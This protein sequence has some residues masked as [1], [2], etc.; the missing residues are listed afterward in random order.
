VSEYTDALP[1]EELAEEIEELIGQWTLDRR[2]VLEPTWEEVVL[3]FRRKDGTKVW[4]HKEA[5]GWRSDTYV[6]VLKQKVLSAKALISDQVLQGGKLPVGLLPDKGTEE[7]LADQEEEV[8]GQADE[9]R[10]TEEA[11]LRSQLERTGSDAKY[12][13][14]LL[15]GALYGQAYARLRL[16]EREERMRVPV[17]E[18]V[19]MGDMGL[20]R[21]EEE[22]KV[23]EEL[24]W[25]VVSVWDV[26]RDYSAQDCQS[27]Q[28]VALR[29]RLSAAELRSISGDGQGW[30]GKNVEDVIAEAYE[31]EDDDGTGRGGAETTSGQPGLRDLKY[32]SAPLE[33]WEFWGRVP[34]AK[35]TQEDAGRKKGKP[36]DEAEVIAV[37][38]EGRLLRVMETEAARPV[39]VVSWWD[40]VDHLPASG[41]A[42]NLLDVQRMMNGAVRA[43]EDNKKL[44]AN[45]MP[46]VKDEMLAVPMKNWAPGETVR[47]VDEVEDVTKAVTILMFPDV[48]Q[49]L[50]EVIQ[51]AGSLADD[52][53]GVPRVQ[54]GQSA[55]GKETAYELSQ[56]LEKSGKLL[57]EVI[58]HYDELIEWLA[59]EFHAD[60]V[61]N[62]ELPDGQLGFRVQA[63][64]FTSF[65]ARLELIQSITQLL[66]VVG[67]NERLMGEVNWREVLEAMAKALDM[68]P[69]RFLNA[70]ENREEMEGA[71][72]EQQAAAMA[73]EQEMAAAALQVQQAKAMKDEAG[74]EKTAVDAK[75]AAE[76]LKL[77]QL[78][79]AKEAIAAAREGL[80]TGPETT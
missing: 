38:C 80:D 60:N 24:D 69:D 44:T 26:V 7:W 39:K 15:Q 32:H 37:V 42:E 11:R 67:Q 77:R 50:A 76:D 48:A 3:A 23:V 13:E 55:P 2:T 21:S 1:G 22:V 49:Q 53:S 57:G 78:R 5:Q 8:Q 12:G 59:G 47:V 64:G 31:D 71:M 56:R 9:W 29:S 41:I 4:K 33:V 25:A 6:A 10:E 30:L 54:Q 63:L 74:A 16:V 43:F 73:L 17:E 18:T 46:V 61:A 20:L 51:F 45:A 70:V 58:R 66:T 62:E 36:G 34:V 68:D 52:E 79:E 35:L 27:G 72:Q 75:V 40:G 65:R 19:G 14:A 28:G